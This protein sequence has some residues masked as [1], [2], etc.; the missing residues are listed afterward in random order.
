MNNSQSQYCLVLA[1]LFIPAC[2]ETGTDASSESE[3]T[4][5]ESTDTADTDTEGADTEGPDMQ[6]DYPEPSGT[7]PVGVLDFEV[8]DTVYPVMR[9][10]DENGRRLLV[11]VWY[12]AT[13]ADGERRIYFEGDELELV[14][15]PMLEAISAFIPDATLIDPLADI[16]THSY[17]GVEVATKSDG[18]PVVVYSHGGLS[19]LAQN[20]ALM[21]ELAS[22][23]YLVY[24]I[25]HPG[26][27]SG[28]LYL[29]GEVDA[30]DSDFQEGVLAASTAY[31]P[32]GIGSD[33]IAIRYQAKTERWIDEGSYLGPWAPRWRDDKLAVVDFIE[34]GTATGRLADVLAQSDV[35]RL[36]YFGMSY[37]ASAAGSAAQ[38]DGRAKAVVNLDGS[39]WLSDLLDTEI[40][41]PLL[42]LT[43][44][45]IDHSYSNEFFYEPL[46]SMGERDDITRVWLPDVTHLELF[47]IMFLPAEH[48]ANFPGGGVADG[49]EVHAIL[50]SFIRSFLDHHLRS[51]DNGYPEANF[52]A[53]PDVRSVD[54]TYVRQWAQQP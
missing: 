26:Q 25:G 7:Y 12:P 2:G 44:E 50:S 14:G 16:R 24:S 31:E 33:D 19:Q 39:H 29:D 9:S 18:F 34:A 48:R 27:S 8:L 20:T 53:F 40:R 11:R 3:T 46:V 6:Y 35:S 1:L 10:E 4:G 30:Y 51:Q 36:A 15:R 37:G 13:V 21:E 32:D 41:V 49:P 28:V 42:A 45:Y 47:D 43:T 54:L 22:H 52:A 38:I 5:S 17:K 23:G